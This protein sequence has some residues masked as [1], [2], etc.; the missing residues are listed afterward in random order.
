MVLNDTGVGL[1]INGKSFPATGAIVAGQGEKV[2]VRFMNEGL[3][4][5][6]MHLHGMY[7]Q[8]IA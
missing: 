4:I 2:R 1:T 5:H 6:P 7:M 8:V 3:V